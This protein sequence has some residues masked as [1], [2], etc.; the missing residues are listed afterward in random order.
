MCPDQSSRCL[1]VSSRH[2]QC[3]LC[4]SVCSAREGRACL[5]GSQGLGGVAAAQVQQAQ[6]QKRPLELGPLGLDLPG[7]PCMPCRVKLPPHTRARLHG[8]VVTL[9]AAGRQSE[10][11]WLCFLGHAGSM[12]TEC[13][14]HVRWGLACRVLHVVVVV[15]PVNSSHKVCGLLSSQAACQQIVIGWAALCCLLLLF[16]HAATGVA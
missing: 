1:V 8:K 10:Q 14:A 6:A 3:Q 5:Q 7:P 13:A 12:T 2:R 15:Q 9:Q 16:L 11:D 4:Q